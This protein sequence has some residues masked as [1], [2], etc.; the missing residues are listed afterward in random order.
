MSGRARLL[1]VKLGGSVFA[2][3]EGV[4]ECANFVAN[5]TRSG[6]KVVAV[7]SALNGE[8][9]RL[10]GTLGRLNP[11]V[12]PSSMDDVLSMGERTSARIFHS[13]LRALGI[14]STLVDVDTPYWPVVTDD[15]H[16][17]AS[18]LI[19]ETCVN[20]NQRLLPLL[21]RGD[22]PVVCGF[23]GLSKSGRVTTLGRGGSDTTAT[24]LGRC[25]KV[26]EVIL[27]KDVDGVLD[28]SP[29]EV[30]GPGRLGSL[31]LSELKMMARSGAKVVAEKSLN[32]VEGYRLRITSLAAGLSSGTV[33]VDDS[34]GDEFRC[35]VVSD[36]ISMVTILSPKGIDTHTE[37]SRMIAERGSV[38][39]AV[40]MNGSS[41][42][43]YVSGEL[44]QQRLH[45]L[46]RQGLAK[47]VSVRTGLSCVSVTGSGFGEKPGMIL[48][49]TRP[50][51]DESMNL[52]GFST[53]GDSAKIFLSSVD[54]HRAV[55]LIERSIRGKKEAV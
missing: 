15:N 32:Y 52:Y 16:G 17:D 20:A 9:D 5:L 2:G 30:S 48:H 7:V 35:E 55:E 28:S 21:E 50:L 33:V 39:I 18:P 8:T 10:L 46:V 37:L 38:L 13:A 24:L 53:I 14:R 42:L 23:I 31:T 54:A 40:S 3:P 4:K 36:K 41:A 12:D 43:Y 49:I 51:T 47:A 27:I 22:V 19:E 25:L 1:V 29:L 11:G 34:F 26:D 45:S 44:D 6:H